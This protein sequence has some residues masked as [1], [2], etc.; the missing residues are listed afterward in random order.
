MVSPVHDGLLKCGVFCDCA[1]PG[2]VVTPIWDKAEAQDVSMYDSTPYKSAL[3]AFGK[4]M[5]DDGRAG[6]SPEHIGRYQYA[7][8]A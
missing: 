8:L 1:G 4:I 3:A 2:A 6:H 5:V 7:P